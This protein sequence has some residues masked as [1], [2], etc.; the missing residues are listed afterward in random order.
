VDVPASVT[1]LEGGSRVITANATGNGL[2]YA[3]FP[4]TGLNDATIANPTVTGTGDLTYRVTVT[5][6]KGC[7]QFADVTVTVLKTPGVPNAFTPN[8][9]GINDT[10]EVR[11]LDSYPGCTVNIFNRNG[12]KVFSSIGYPVPWDGRTNNGN[13]STGV[14]YYIIDPKNGRKTMSGYITIIK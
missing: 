3:W 6:D 5:N 11:H 9:D 7:Q 8:G 2:T 1:V 12:Q 10:W 4:A 13:L 14:Y